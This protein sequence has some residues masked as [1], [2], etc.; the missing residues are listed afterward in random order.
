[1][2]VVRVSA[3]RIGRLYPRGDMHDTHFCWRL[4]RP[5]GYSAAG[6]IKLMKN[7]KTPSGIKPA[8]S[9]CLNLSQ[10][11]TVD[12]LYLV[13]LVISILILISY[14]CTNAFAVSQDIPPTC[15]LSLRVLQLSSTDLYKALS[16]DFNI[17]RKFLLVPH[18]NNL[19]SRQSA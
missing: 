8:T 6:R 5:Q 14:I 1:M 11:K 16:V 15:I 4:N 13:I 3:L 18:Q 2:K 7:P 17:S 19:V 9:R 12:Q 10:T